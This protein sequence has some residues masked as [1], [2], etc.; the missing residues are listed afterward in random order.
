[1]SAPPK[2]AGVV[3]TKQRRLKLIAEA[4]AADLARIETVKDVALRP[5]LAEHVNAHFDLMLAIR[6]QRYS[7]KIRLGD[8]EEALALYM[9]QKR[10]ETEM[11]E[12]QFDMAETRQIIPCRSNAIH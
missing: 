7:A 8:A 4:R 9:E 11:A 2:R 5:I 10:H 3:T 12:M 6:S 1:M